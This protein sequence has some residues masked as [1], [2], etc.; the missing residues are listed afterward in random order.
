[1]Q[2][3]LLN[4]VVRLFHV[5]KHI[6]DYGE[7][8]V[9]YKLY[10]NTRAKHNHDSGT[11]VNENNE[12]VYDY[13]KTFNIRSYVPVQETDIIEFKG[14]RYRIITIE[15]RREYNDILIKSELINE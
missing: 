9:N 15:K 6:N 7:E 13:T 12:I 8:T 11:R 5:E 4:E 10:F 3:G 1:M 14:K 2:A